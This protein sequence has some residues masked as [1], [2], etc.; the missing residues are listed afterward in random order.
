MLANALKIV[1]YHVSNVLGSFSFRFSSC[2]C[3][4]RAP[5]PFQQSW[6]YFPGKYLFRVCQ[7]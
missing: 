2:Q 1:L 3:L 5:V 4:Q 6:L 7:F